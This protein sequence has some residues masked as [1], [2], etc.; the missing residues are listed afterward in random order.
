MIKTSLGKSGEE[1]D[2]RKYCETGA[3]W[4]GNRVNL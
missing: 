2:S 1:H 4:N 3:V